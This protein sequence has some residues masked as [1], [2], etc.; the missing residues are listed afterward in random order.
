MAGKWID[1]LLRY[2]IYVNAILVSIC[3]TPQYDL[4]I[5]TLPGALNGLR[6]I[7]LGDVL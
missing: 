1:E 2:H 4:R 5:Q 6:E 3:R 7:T